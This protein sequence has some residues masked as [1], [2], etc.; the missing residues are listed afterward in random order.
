MVCNTSNI[1][2]LRNKT[3]QQKTKFAVSVQASH[4][5]S[6]GKQRRARKT[7]H[8]DKDNNIEVV[9]SSECATREEYC[10]TWY[11]K[12]HYRKFKSDRLKSIQ[13]L[14][15][16]NFDIS[17]LEPLQHCLHGIENYHT[18]QIIMNRRSRVLS[19]EENS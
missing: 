10:R 8:F 7:V 14:D 2:L 9:L 5:I 3:T 19:Q 1:A 18:A 17:S 11:N 6:K 4:I 15:H 12:V 16:V 13:V